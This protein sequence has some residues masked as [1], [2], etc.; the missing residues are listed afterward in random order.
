[1][2]SI[3]LMLLLLL[4]AAVSAAAQVPSPTPTPQPAPDVRLVTVDD[5]VSLFM[6][7][8][9]QLVAAR[10]D[11]ETADAEKIT[12]RL[13]PNPV[14]TV[15]GS[16]IP[17]KFTGPL[18][19]DDSFAYNISQDLELGGKR[20]KRITVAEANAELARAQ[21]EVAVWQMTNDLKRKFYT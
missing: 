21:F 16:G 1:M 20:K 18:I 4:A 10:Y 14:L 17:V 8:N 19:Q 9:L 12:A 3:F 6:Q 13:R 11:I 2:K 7:Q 5:A 15:G